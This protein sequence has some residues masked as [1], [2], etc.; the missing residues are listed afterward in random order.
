[1]ESS[2]SVKCMQCQHEN[3]V[4]NRFCTECGNELLQKCPSCEEAVSA[5]SKFCGHC[6]FNLSEKKEK[7]ATPTEVEVKTEP[8]VKPEVKP[9]PNV[10]TETKIEPETDT[11]LLSK[12]Q[13]SGEVKNA[14]V[15][16]AD[17]CNSSALIEK[18]G[19]E[20]AREIL[21]P[22]L[23]TMINSVTRHS[24]TVVKVAGDG[25]MALFGAPIAYEDHAIRGCI[26]ALDIQNSVKNNKEMK[27][28]SVRI[29]LHSGEVLVDMVGSGDFSN[30]DALG[31]VVSLA[32][33]MEQ[34]AEPGTVQITKQTK[35]QTRDFS[36]VKSR[37]KIKVKGFAEKIEIYEIKSID[38]SK[39]RFS[40]DPKGLTP[41]VDKTKEIQVIEEQLNKAKIRDSRVLGI[42]GEAGYGKSRFIYEFITSEHAKDCESLQCYCIADQI[43]V[44][45][46]PMVNYLKQ[47]LTITP[48]DNNE[49]KKQKIKGLLDATNYKSEFSESA[50]YS[51]LEIDFSDEKWD[52]LPSLKKREYIFEILTGMFFGIGENNTL[53]MILEDMQWADSE[54]IAF[55]NH[56]IEHLSD[57]PILLIVSFRPE[58]EHDWSQ[59]ESYT[60]IEL[61]ALQY[62][63]MMKML[64][65]LL[66]REVGSDT[67]DLGK[68][69]IK[70][71][72]QCE[73]NPLFL[74][75][76]ITVLKDKKYFSS[77]SRLYQIT[78]QVEKLELPNTIQSITAARID[79]LDAREKEL[80]LVS[81]VI[82][83]NF[84]L[85]FCE[86][87]TGLSQKKVGDAI[88]NLIKLG[89]LTKSGL[90]QNA[91]YSF[92]HPIT[93]EVSNRILLKKKKIMLHKTLVGLIEEYYKESI[94]EKIYVLAN[95]AYKAELWEK[96][97]Q[98]SHK[99]GK[100]AYSVYANK[101]AMLYYMKEFESFEKLNKENRL[102]YGGETLESRFNY[103]D[104]KIKFLHF[105]E[106]VPHLAETLKIANFIKD[107]KNVARTYCGLSLHYG[108]HRANFAKGC[109]YAK[110]ALEVA[111]SI[112]DAQITMKAN[113]SLLHVHTFTGHYED[114]LKLGSGMLKDMRSHLDEKEDFWFPHWG[115]TYFLT[116]VSASMIGEFDL[117]H[118]LYDDVQ[119]LKERERKHVGFFTMNV[120]LA[121]AFISLKLGNFKKSEPL[122][123]DL[124]LVVVELEV[125]LLSIMIYSNLAP[126]YLMQD[127]KEEALTHAKVVEAL[128]DTMNYLYYTTFSID[129]LVETYIGLENFDK[130]NSTIENMLDIAKKLDRDDLKVMMLR[131]MGNVAV[132]S[133]SSDDASI[134]KIYRDAIKM[135][136]EIKLK[137]HLAHCHLDLSKFYIKCERI[138]E[139]KNELNLAIGFF[140]EMK[141]DYWKEKGSA[142]LTSLK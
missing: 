19:P 130:A 44:P 2:K 15:L 64:D 57:V 85:Y 69:K 65:F 111:G 54:T 13:K 6:G 128:A 21:E 9:E 142:L 94:N 90:D 63:Y 109:K 80:L 121:E 139:A 104:L 40:M 84:T 132:V 37:G 133:G 87:L 81:S 114:A 17:I 96:A 79:K 71:L 10:K 31:P 138:D 38:L 7:T 48:H 119:K 42:S 118:E 141:M 95:H 78:Q 55:I 140:G 124:L 24:G 43:S 126:I 103:Y 28:I 106:I 73:G 86:K 23:K 14:T 33:R 97:F 20:D 22:V 27:E 108:A 1:M 105:S 136:S 129:S 34:T 117:Y 53:I 41:F 89:F 56:L 12:P 50:L 25:I 68:L 26:A 123:N 36:K 67:S 59:N 75:E 93:K 76:T 11:S 131:L 62:K 58:F 102:K 98:Y 8:E 70:I 30:Y 52:T 125:P 47:H 77:D 110:K 135:A 72:N 29:G 116:V 61:A 88:E 107:K 115:L 5:E 101:E 122:L 39:S 82:G 74:E 134:E 35:E 137:P 127:K 45:L 32:A 91:E 83:D 3:P 16:F 120:N 92:K 49:Q 18:L 99:A 51:L 112:Q 46:Y 60:Q 100:K 66:E 113:F 4:V